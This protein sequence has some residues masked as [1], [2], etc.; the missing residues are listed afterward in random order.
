M[1]E[2]LEW[3]EKAKLSTLIFFRQVTA[4][5]VNAT[6]VLSDSLNFYG[7]IVLY[8]GTFECAAY[9]IMNLLCQHWGI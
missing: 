2:K 3:A 1:D 8:V 6:P 4:P 5:P 7:T 9:V